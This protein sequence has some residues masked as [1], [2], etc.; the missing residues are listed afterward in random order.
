[1]EQDNLE[2]QQRK[3]EWELFSQFEGKTRVGTVSQREKTETARLINKILEIDTGMTAQVD[4]LDLALRVL[5]IKNI[6]TSRWE[7]RSVIQAKLKLLRRLDEDEIADE[8]CKGEARK[9][10][11]EAGAQALMEYKQQQQ[12]Q[13]QQ[14]QQPHEMINVET[15]FEEALGDS[16]VIA[17]GERTKPVP[18]Y[19]VSG[20]PKAWQEATEGH[21]S[22]VG[23]DARNS[24]YVN[25]DNEQLWA[26]NLFA[27]EDNRSPKVIWMIHQKDTGVDGIQAAAAATAAAAAARN[28]ER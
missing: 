2:E 21:Y 19:S 9:M 5:D 28:D 3:K 8:S 26:A 24:L 13:Q 25:K 17:G 10:V 27:V 12:Q 16:A 23:N 18:F 22:K 4:T 20:G 15:L 11:I 1:M 6:P 14:P 7:I